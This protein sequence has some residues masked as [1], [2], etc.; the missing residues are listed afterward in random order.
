MAGSNFVELIFDLFQ[1]TNAI[2][3]ASRQPG[4]SP[5]GSNS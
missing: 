4:I 5:K 3:V 2:L 1:H